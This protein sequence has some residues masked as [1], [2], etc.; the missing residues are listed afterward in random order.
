M[1]QPEALSSLQSVIA[2]IE[3]QLL[4]VGRRI[5]LK[6]HLCLSPLA[7]FVH[8]MCLCVFVSFCSCGPRAQDAPSFRPFCVAADLLILRQ[9]DELEKCRFILSAQFPP[10]TL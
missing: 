4:V 7:V 3:R 10:I 8:G 2:L 1:L 5:L 9:E 6:P